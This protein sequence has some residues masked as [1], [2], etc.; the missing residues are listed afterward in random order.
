MPRP[1]AAEK[2]KA[3]PISNLASLGIYVFNYEML[4]R[5]L[6]SDAARNDSVHDFGNNIIPGM[7]AED[8][9]FCYEFRDYWRDV[10]TIQGSSR[11]PRTRFR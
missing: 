11:A 9:V 7:I 8:R 3:A 1:A 2:P 10:G 4:V 6:K 5:R